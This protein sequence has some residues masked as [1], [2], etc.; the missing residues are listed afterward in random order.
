MLRFELGS[1]WECQ[2]LGLGSD[3]K[4][5]GLGLGSDWECESLG[6]GMSRFGLGSDWGCRDFL[7][8]VT[9]GAGSVREVPESQSCAGAPSPVLLLCNFSKYRPSNLFRESGEDSGISH[10][11]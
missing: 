3:W 11:D 6:L 4:C 1:D 9:A 7:P 8:K 5:Q 2:G 10:R